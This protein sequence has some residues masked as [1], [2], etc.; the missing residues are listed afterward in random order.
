MRAISSANAGASGRGAMS[1][2]RRAVA[3]SAGSS[4]HNSRVA[5]SLGSTTTIGAPR[6]A[7]SSTIWPV[8]PRPSAGL[9]SQTATRMSDWASAVRPAASKAADS[10]SSTRR[11]GI[12]GK[13]QD[14]GCAGARQEQPEFLAR[15]V[16]NERLGVDRRRAGQNDVEGEAGV[17]RGAGGDAVGA[18]GERRDQRHDRRGFAEARLGLGADRGEARGRGGERRFERPAHRRDVEGPRRSR[19][20]FA[21][22]GEAMTGDAERQRQARLGRVMAHWATGSGA[23]DG[24]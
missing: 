19:P 15:R 17:E 2:A 20:G 12:A 18:L 10:R 7:A 4:A 3:A 6:R 21:R 1:S 5:P 22:A 24:R 23:E 11:G 9:P 14:Q 13:R 16:V 8:P